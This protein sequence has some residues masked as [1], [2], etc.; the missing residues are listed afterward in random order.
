MKKIVLLLF[1]V[2]LLIIPVTA[3]AQD[4]ESLSDAIDKLLS[5]WK[6]N[7][8]SPSYG[9]TFFMIII[10]KKGE[11]AYRSGSAAVSISLDLPPYLQYLLC[12]LGRRSSAG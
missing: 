11:G 6:R 8:A 3:F 5:H 7:F 9:L 1:A 10:M 4:E 12:A 2:L